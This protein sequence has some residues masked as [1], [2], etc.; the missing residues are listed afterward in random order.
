[1]NS[2]PWS[3]YNVGS[4]CFCFFF[5]FA[6]HPWYP[7]ATWWP[8]FTTAIV[9][10]KAAQ[11]NKRWSSHTLSVSQVLEG[12]LIWMILAWSPGSSSLWRPHSSEILKGAGGI[13][14]ASWPEVSA[15]PRWLN[16]KVSTCNVGDTGSVP[17]LG[18]S[19]GQR[20]LAGYSPWGCKEL[21]TIEHS[22]HTSVPHCTALTIVPLGPASGFPSGQVDLR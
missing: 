1:M 16:S 17:G 22:T 7:C 12:W 3:L 8:P 11:N 10:S 13:P 20:I 6:F 5:F 19:P 2:E 4:S 18:R 14:S 15:P 21:G 9:F